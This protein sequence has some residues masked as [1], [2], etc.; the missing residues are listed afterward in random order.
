MPI[1]LAIRNGTVVTPSAALEAHDIFCDGDGKIAAIQPTTATVSLPEDCEVIDAAGALV[2]PGGIDPHVHFA[3]PQGPYRLLSSDDWRTGPAAAACGGTTTVV[4]FVEP[5]RRE[6]L[7]AAFETRRREAEQSPIDF[8]LHMCLNR[9]DSATLGG[10]QHVVEQLGVPTLKI[11]TAYDGIRLTDAELL[12]AFSAIARL[13]ALPIIHA[14]CHEM[15]MYR[16]TEAEIAGKGH[17]IH[18]A[19]TRP[20][21]NEV[22]AT[23][24][25]LAFAD[26]L[27]CPVH[28]V[29]VSAARAADAIDAESLRRGN[30]PTEWF[31]PDAT[32][33]LVSGEVCGHHL[34]LDHATAFGSDEEA[35]DARVAAN[36]LCAPPLREHSDCEALAGRL[37]QPSAAALFT[38]S[39]H[40]PFTTLQRTGLATRPDI[41]TYP[42][43]GERTDLGEA[44]GAAWRPT[45][46]VPAF[47]R[48]PGGLAGVQH[49]LLVTYDAAVKAGASSVKIADLIAG[50]A[51][52]RYGLR[53][54]GRLAVG[55][56]ADLVIIDPSQQ[57]TLCVANSRE[58]V[59]FSPFEGMS[60]QGSIR[61][62]V[63]RSRVLVRAGKPTEALAAPG[64]RFVPRKL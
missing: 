41:A 3:Y 21:A 16:V 22:E 8:G 10:L 54:K 39:D 30:R 31:G 6:T 43:S 35:M 11:Y 7:L 47:W 23:A 60:V 51:A 29:H 50:A 55:L 24:R 58:N 20:V 45:S 62:V 1:V 32:V 37:A 56:D 40:C 4:D 14:E 13:P 46:D 17:P 63:S 64:G 25:V 2:F 49:R 33:P 53:D 5:S 27:N 59:D 36:L 44:R 26:A 34:V 38:V 28:I 52:R 19:A 12:R 42:V 15:I 61:T 9:V 18:H 57:T 48:M